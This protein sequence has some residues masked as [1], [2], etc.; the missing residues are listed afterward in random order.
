LFYSGWSPEDMEVFK[1]PMCLISTESVENENGGEI[2]NNFKEEQEVLN[3]LKQIDL[4]MVI[5]AV[6]G[7]YRT[8][9]SYLMNLLAESTTGKITG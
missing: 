9:K 7:L 5:V 8:G 3:Q 4:P 6:V 1:H 2:K